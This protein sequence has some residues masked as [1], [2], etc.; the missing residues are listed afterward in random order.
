M[1]TLARDLAEASR[2]V[3]RG[4]RAD[5]GADYAHIT[6]KTR[7]PHEAHAG[8]CEASRESRKVTQL[9]RRAT[10][11]AR[12]C[13]PLFVHGLLFTQNLDVT[14][15]ELTRGQS[16]FLCKCLLFKP[17]SSPSLATL[18]PNR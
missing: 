8:F 3:T 15:Q 10:D 5:H 6:H 16:S 1:I 12:P 2:E 11:E 14:K 7:T 17:S 18:N 9:F 13:I 4:S